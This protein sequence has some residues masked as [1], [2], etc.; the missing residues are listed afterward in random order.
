MDENLVRI[1]MAQRSNHGVTPQ[2]KMKPRLLKTRDAAQYIGMH[3]DML[4]RF[5]KKGW[6]RSFYFPGCRSKRW[7]VMEL[8]RM[9]D[10]IK[11]GEIR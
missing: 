10:K 9:I 11:R 2:I 8:N 4:I 1:I 5:E 3:P 6:V 7:D